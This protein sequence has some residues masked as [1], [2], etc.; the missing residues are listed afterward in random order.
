MAASHLAIDPSAP[1][2][3]TAH[4]APAQPTLLKYRTVMGP[5]V[6]VL[7]L[8]ALHLATV[9]PG[10]AMAGCW[11][12]VKALLAEE[13]EGKVSRELHPRLSEKEL[14]G[15]YSFD[16]ANSPFFQVVMAMYL[17]LLLQVWSA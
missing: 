12:R 4:C 13:K 5:P 3:S 17:P 10:W 15:W 9:I 14:R 1:W 6:P 8:Q 7:S 11:D 2:A 16:F